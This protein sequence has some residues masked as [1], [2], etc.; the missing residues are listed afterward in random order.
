[1]AATTENFVY[2]KFDTCN[3][4]SVFHL[5]CRPGVPLAADETE[6]FLLTTFKLKTVIVLVS[7]CLSLSKIRLKEIDGI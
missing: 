1:M 5:T 7:L 2:H 4:C 6:Q 3:I